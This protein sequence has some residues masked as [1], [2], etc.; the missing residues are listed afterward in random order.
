MSSRKSK[1]RSSAYHLASGI[2]FLWLIA[3]GSISSDPKDPVAL[4]GTIGLALPSLFFLLA[5][6]ATFGVI[7]YRAGIIV[8]VIM[9]T[10]LGGGAVLEGEGT[11]LTIFII[12]FVTALIVLHIWKG[13]TPTINPSIIGYYNEDEDKLFCNQCITS[14]EISISTNEYAII[15]E[16]DLRDALY[17]CDNCGRKITEEGMERDDSEIEDNFSGS[18]A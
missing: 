9:G 8:L 12:N 7:S 3:V 6:A 5:P 2:I 11:Q 1:N 4:A 10:I 16:D 18:E 15:E 17:L 13:P 14:E